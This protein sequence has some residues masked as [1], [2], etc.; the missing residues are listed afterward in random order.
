MEAEIAWSITE[1]SAKMPEG[2]RS[3]SVQAIGRKSVGCG[4]AESWGWALGLR[5]GLVSVPAH[6]GLK[7]G[8]EP[9]VREVRPLKAR[10]A[11]G[12]VQRSLAEAT[13][14]KYAY[15]TSADLVVLPPL[16]RLSIRLDLDPEV[17]SALRHAAQGQIVVVM[18]MGMFPCGSSTNTPR[19]SRPSLG[20][21]TSPE[22]SQQVA[23]HRINT[24]GFGIHLLVRC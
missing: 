2:D 18:G 16:R 15:G 9:R 8:S 14:T 24:F 7:V 17:G 4:G 6:Q 10:E 20:I 12:W 11:L 1:T 21:L 3:G 22:C 13:I 23:G 5:A 19:P